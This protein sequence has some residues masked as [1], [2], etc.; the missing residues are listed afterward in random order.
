[1]NEGVKETV[2][3]LMDIGRVQC[4]Y[5]SGPVRQPKVLFVLRGNVNLQG[6]L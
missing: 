4:M 1:M 2:E 3:A 6:F 5:K